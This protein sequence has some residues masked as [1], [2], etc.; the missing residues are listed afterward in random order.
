MCDG[1][2]THTLL[3][4]V[5]SIQFSTNINTY[6]DLDKKVIK[7]SRSR[8][9]HPIVTKRDTQVGLIRI[10]VLSKN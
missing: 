2:H 4:V 10:Q 5:I 3:E 7:H 6:V 8:N 1:T 9:I